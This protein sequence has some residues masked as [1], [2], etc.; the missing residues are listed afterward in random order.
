MDSA[1]QLLNLQTL[2]S[3]PWEFNFAVITTSAARSLNTSPVLSPKA[4]HNAA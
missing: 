3:I 1:A 4:L 2:I